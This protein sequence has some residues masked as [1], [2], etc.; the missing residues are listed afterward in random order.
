MTT[1][2]IGWIGLGKMGVPMSKQLIKA[3]YAVT[4]YNRSKEKEAALVE[5][6][7]AIASSPAALIKQSDIII[8]M[9][10]D[11]NAIRDIF[12]K[13]D[14]LLSA[15]TTGKVIINMSTVSSSI[16]KEFSAICKQHGNHYLDAPVSGSVKQAEDGVLVIM[17][18]GE[19]SVFQQVKP[20]LEAM[21]KMALRVGDA[22]AGNAAKLAINSLLSFHALGLA[23]AVVF[24][25]KNGINTADLITMINNGAL[26]NAFM[27]IKGDAILHQNF[28]AA[29]SL[30]QIVKDLGL[31]KSEGLDT[32]LGKAAFETFSSAANEYGEED[33]IA[34]VKRLREG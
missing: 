24:A 23:E 1:T 25:E 30:K 4:V 16:S 15:N 5:M 2:S 22:G 27:K 11:D 33:L 14:G 13:P 21:G 28:H 19:E 32:P 18:G 31:A 9:V 7:A 20:V 3:G 12:N 17:V 8:L 26:G 10:S 34:V 6:G 29:F